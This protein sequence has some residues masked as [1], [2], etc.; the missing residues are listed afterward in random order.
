M[1]SLVGQAREAYDLDFKQELYSGSDRGK[2]DLC[3]DVAA[4]ANTAGGVILVGVQDE[5]ATASGVPGVEVTDDV[6]NRIRQVVA[7]GVTPLPQFDV[8]GVQDPGQASRGVLVIAVP[9]S[10]TRPHGVLINEGLRFPRRNGATIAY[11]AEPEVAD[12]YRERFR[13]ADDADRTLRQY[14]ASVISMLR[15]GQFSYLVLSLQP[16]VLGDVTIDTASL[17]TFKNDV[18]GRS[19][20]IFDSEC[21]WSDARVASGRFI[22]VHT[23]NED[24]SPTYM[25]CELYRTGGGAIA[26]MIGRPPDGPTSHEAADE[27]RHDVSDEQCVDA[28]LG[29]LMFLGWH[30]RDRAATGGTVSVRATTWP[31][32]ASDLVTYRSYQSRTRIGVLDAERPPMFESV[33]DLDDIAEPGSALVA[34]ASRMASGLLQGFGLPEAPQL[35]PTGA[36]RINYWSGYRRNA[37]TSWTTEHNIEISKESI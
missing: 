28:V 3:S 9:R 34:A 6:I 7:G 19:V 18:V 29:A 10:P 25:A 8:F 2:R 22:A 21:T 33:F 32:A 17:R 24:R 13:R 37:V 27:S 5:H 20:R 11:L 26:I 35:S 30:A 15:P 1:V 4:M 16:D 12:A 23:Y 31:N 36:V 14:E